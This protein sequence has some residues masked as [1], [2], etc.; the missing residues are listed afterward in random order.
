M[1]LERYLK[2]LHDEFARVDADGNGVIDETDVKLHNEVAM[3]MQRA[4]GS[5][6]IMSADLDGD[7]VVTEAELRQKLHYDRRSMAIAPSR[8]GMSV[9][10]QIDTEVRRLMAADADKDGRITWAEAQA[11]A[12][13]QPQYQQMSRWGFG[14][15]A[16]QLIGLAPAGKSAITWPELEA[17]ATAFFQKADADNNGT[18]SLDELEPVRS[19]IQR[20]AM[21]TV[22]A[23]AVRQA[24]ANCNLPKASEGTKVVLLSAYE[25]EALST[26]AL[27]SQDELTGVGNVNVEPGSEPLYIVLSSYRPTIWRF[28]GSTERIE[29]VVATAPGHAPRKGARDAHDA[30]EAPIAGVLGVSADRVS[31]PDRTNCPRYFTEQPSIAAAEAGGVVKASAGKSPEVVAARYKVGTFSVPSGKI[32]AVPSQASQGLLIIQKSGGT[33]T[34]E[35]DA[36]KIKIVGPGSAASDNG[37][38]EYNPGGVVSIDPKKVVASVPVEAYA[39]LPQEAGL[40]QLIKSGALTEVSSREL[41]INEKIRFPAGLYGAHSRKFLLRKNVAMPEG[42]PG[43]SRVVSEETG[44][45]VVFK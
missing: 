21:D 4:A 12:K 7:G 14:A 42:N 13:N 6:A 15:Q 34:V 5:M 32:E 16:T 19:R 2:S 23:Q 30:K 45:P 44:E 11:F 24:S 3:A 20:A 17:A 28:Y 27:G 18:I 22:R 9:E 41:M 43:H 37:L 35:G 25:T 26:A 10:E 39:V 38:R 1:T 8:P 40:A 29:R 31:F 33:L 36:S